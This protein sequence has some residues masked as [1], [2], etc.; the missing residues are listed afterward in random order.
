[1]RPADKKGGSQR[2]NEDEGLCAL[3]SQK[4]TVRGAGETGS[5]RKEKAQG[6]RYCGVGFRVLGARLICF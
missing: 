5:W 2:A 3:G 1:M 4:G 6:G